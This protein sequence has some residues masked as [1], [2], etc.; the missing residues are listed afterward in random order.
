MKEKNTVI[1]VVLDFLR[2]IFNTSNFRGKGGRVDYFA[3]RILIASS[4][5]SL[6][7]ATEKLMEIMEVNIGN[8]NPLKFASYVKI[9]QTDYSS[10]VLYWLRRQ[11][12][13]IAK[14]V[15]LDAVSYKQ[16]TEDLEDNLLPETDD[17][18]VMVKNREYPISISA[19]LLSPLSHGSETK[20]GNATFYRTMTGMS[21]RDKAL[22]L[23][24]YSGLAL[25][26]QMRDLLADELLSELGLKPSR[27]K[28]P[29]NLW[30]F[31]ILYGGGTLEEGGKA[32]KEISAKLGKN[33]SVYGESFYELRNLLPNI[34]ILG[35]A[36]GDRTLCGHV[37]AFGDLH[38]RCRQWN[39][40]TV[41]VEELYEWLFLT[42]REDFEGHEKKKKGG[43]DSEAENVSMIA[44]MQCLRVGVELVG[45]IETGNHMSELELS[46]L[47]RGLELLEEN[48]YLGGKNGAGY[49]RV[50]FTFKNKPDST[51]YKDFLKNNKTE[52][53]EYIKGIGAINEP[54]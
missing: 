43:S 17:E 16:L 12:K 31:Q 3:N 10:R 36:L 37:L 11:Y 2:E 20:A 39:N 6:T 48:G 7:A 28:P 4:N 25:R 13:I 1:N 33:G 9:S 45:G 44:N 15:S 38:P 21:D 19:Q 34:S 42:R 53:L 8:I 30:F 32:A 46:C 40:G 5:S 26:G 49:G 18:G 35:S 50:Q 23:P 41:D 14:I 27:T 54:D 47:G 24:Y 22:E 51:M 29:I 52:I